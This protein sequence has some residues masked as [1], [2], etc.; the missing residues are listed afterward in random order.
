VRRLAILLLPVLLALPAGAGAAPRPGLSDVRHVWV[1]VLENKDFDDTFGADT[2]AP[3]LARELT[4]KG[5]LLR[6]YFGTS[7]ASLGNY[8]TMISGQAPNVATQADCLQFNE[9]FPGIL[10][11]DGQTLGAGCV[12][13]KA[14]P[15]IANQLDDA[16]LRWRGYMEDMPRPCDHPAP[17]QIDDTQSATAASQYATRHNPFVY[18]RAVTDSPTCER[19]VVPLGQ[20]LQD[21]QRPETTP[22]FAFITPDLCNDGHDADCVG[23]QGLGGLPAAD[24]FLRQWVPVILDSP[25]FADHGLLVITWDEANITPESATSCCA[26]PTGPNT[27][28]PGIVGPGGGRTG[29]VVLSPFVEPGS[30]NDTPYN[31]YGLLRTVE[32]VFGLPYLGY[33]GQ[34]GLRSFGQDV[35]GR[36]APVAVPAR[37]R[38]CPSVRRG[39][40]VTGLRLRG[41]VL[42][43]R[44]RRTARVRV[45][46]RRNGR[47]LRL[48]RLTRVDACRSVSLRVPRGTT[49]VTITHGGVRQSARRRPAGDHEAQERALAQSS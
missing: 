18:F 23:N 24:A 36:R 35:L 5:Q 14:I 10:T 16:G 38:P 42:T 33:A 2:E 19:N 49:A 21:V 26:Q 48:R 11:P 44:G 37:P 32:D 31:H 30:V 4:A 8:L 27:V 15:T 1:V 47:A 46:I 43:F 41:R 40:V 28:A 45:T 25:G 6:N 9:I 13:P 12:Y 3:Y 17:G 7:H 39:K 34:A 29:S 20:L 22:N